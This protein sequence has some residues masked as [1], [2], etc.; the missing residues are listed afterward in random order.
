MNSNAPV[1]SDSTARAPESPALGFSERFCRNAVFEALARMPVGNLEITLPDGSQQTFGQERDRPPA[2]IRINNERFFARCVMSGDIGF[3]EAYVDGDWESDDLLGVITWFLNNAE[4]C[5]T[6]SGGKSSFW[7]LNL[8]RAANRLGHLLRP[9]SKSGSRKNIH[10]HYDLGNDFYRLWLDRTLSYSS[11]I[12]QSPD[13][14]LEE[15]QIA[16]YDALCQQLY[17][18]PD[19]HIIEIGCGWGGFAEHAA[20]RYGVN[21]TA[22]TISQEQF[23]FAQQRFADAGLADRIDLRLCDY[24]DIQ[25]AYD[26]VVSI[27]MLEAVGDQFYDTFFRK[28]HSILKPNGLMALQFISAPDARFAEMKRGVDWIQKHIFPGSLLPSIGRVTES[29][30]RTGDLF[31]HNLRDIGNSYARTLKLW[32][33][34]F[35]Q[36]R[37]AVKALGFDDQF[38]RKWNYYLAYCEAAFATRNISAVQAIYTRPNN[39]TLS[40]QS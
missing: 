24:R 1:L 15:A 7:K 27:E 20:S 25:G 35:N 18:T 32:R 2:R 4:N 5:P 36:R 23:N 16:K 21:V 11:A 29:L 26:R 37:D 10:Q 34:K 38:I 31:L 39:R 12:F 13:Q 3:G 22:I 14:S 9:N 33:G 19:T 6:I 17:L 8:L 30:N 40:S 28:C